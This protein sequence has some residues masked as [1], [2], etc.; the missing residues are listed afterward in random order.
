MVKNFL[1][2]FIV[3]IFSILILSGISYA[4][5]IFVDDD[6]DPSVADGSIDY[7]YVDIKSGIEAASDGDTVMVLE[8]TYVISAYPSK[9]PKNLCLS[10]KK[11]PNFTIIDASNSPSPIAIFAGPGWVISGFKFINVGYGLENDGY[12]CAIWN[13][14]R[15][16]G[17]AALDYVNEIC[18]NVFIEPNMR[19]IWVQQK[20]RVLIHHNV[21]IRPKANGIISY[22]FIDVY[23]NTFYNE[24]GLS[25]WG[26]S[27]CILQL[28]DPN[29]D[30]IGVADVRNNIFANSSV[31]L[32]GNDMAVV[33]ESNNLYWNN[34]TDTMNIDESEGGDVFADP[35]FMN[36]DGEDFRIACGSPA[37]DAGVDVGLPYEGDAPEIG[38]YE[39]SGIL[40]TIYVDASADT[41]TADGTAEHPYPGIDMACSAAVDG[42]TILVAPG[43]YGNAYIDPPRPKNLT[44]KSTDGPEVTVI[45]GSETVSGFG[46]VIRAGEGWVID[47]FKFINIGSMFGPDEWCGYACGVYNANPD[48]N[49]VNVV[50][51]CIFVE[52][53]KRGVWVQKNTKVLMDHNVFIKCGANAVMSYGFVDFYNNTVV[54][55]DTLSPYGDNSGFYQAGDNNSDGVAKV[56]NNIFAYNSRGVVRMGDSFLYSSNNLYYEN[57]V[58]TVGITSD[59]GNNV[60]ADPMFVN[61][62]GGDF[63]L[64][65]GSPAID[66]GVDVGLPYEG[67]A[68]EIGAYEGSGV[69]VGIAEESK[70]PRK[71]SLRQNY[72]NPF[73]PTT[74]IGFD[75]PEKA[76]VKV[77][78]YD[79][80]GCEVRTLVDEEMVP[81]RYSIIWDGTNNAGELVPSGV[82]IYSF[83]SK[84]YRSTKKMI[85]V[86]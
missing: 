42:A 26:D 72:P 57:V 44:I 31:G 7:P 37:I 34:S 60:F 62:D 82:Y 84:D 51:N 6:A 5:V 13:D 33:R 22:G 32:R 38:A 74:M 41:A 45:D 18:N 80:L 66:A 65:Y 46:I 54:G 19:A 79:I 68:P 86:R 14:N 17:D 78:I 39:G 59:G 67:D 29:V 63:R 56:K 70:L 2:S 58:D 81:G 4:A 23:N 40:M 12:A 69:E 35:L 71:F 28:A 3:L 76:H 16:E 52:P 64:V 20:T 48:T 25:P 75:I 11:G 47:G 55:T 15:G 85:L 50:R 36:V 9:T 8:G 1:T 83:M 53:H 61:A 77:V 10:S 30:T 27:G 21:F 49:S 24:Q 43:V 73:N